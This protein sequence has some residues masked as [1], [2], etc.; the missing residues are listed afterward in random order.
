MHGWIGCKKRSH[1][2]DEGADAGY[3]SFRLTCLPGNPHMRGRASV[4]HV[5]VITTTTSLAAAESFQIGNGQIIYTGE[6][7]RNR[8]YVD[9]GLL[10]H[11]SPGPPVAFCFLLHI[12]CGVS[13]FQRTK[14]K[15]AV[16]ACATPPR[17]WVMHV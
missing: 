4:L 16:L 6:L 1:S 3:C 17:T 15:C 12:C 14:K 2:L 7:N 13:A 11:E 9:S 10:W 5:I 8:I